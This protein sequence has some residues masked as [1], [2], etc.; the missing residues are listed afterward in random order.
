MS[1]WSCLTPRLS[2]KNFRS[3]W[4]CLRRSSLTSAGWQ[5]TVFYK[6]TSRSSALPLLGFGTSSVNSWKTGIMRRSVSWAYWNAKRVRIIEFSFSLVT[7]CWAS[8]RFRFRGCS[9]T[10]SFVFL[11]TVPSLAASS[12]VLPLDN[13][14]QLC[15]SSATWIVSSLRAVMLWCGYTALTGWVLSFEGTM[16]E[17]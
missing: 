13:P 14:V 6:S 12:T 2:P 4:S 5:F 3:S 11:V 16:P 1:S 10:G 8:Y 9:S 17:G 15:R 7:H